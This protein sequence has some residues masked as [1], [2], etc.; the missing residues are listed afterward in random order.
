MDPSLIHLAKT[1][2]L[3]FTDALNMKKKL[4]SIISTAAIVVSTLMPL[5]SAKAITMSPLFFDY[6]LNPGDTV[7]D[8]IKL[9][10]ETD[11]DR[12]LYPLL[13]NFTYKEGNEDGT[14]EFYMPDQDPTGNALAQWITTDLNPIVIKA[15]ERVNVQFAINVPQNNVQPGGHY[16]A[17]LF[18]TQPPQDD[19]QVGIGGTLGEL[20]LVRVA[21]DVKEE[22]RILEFGFDPKKLWYNY[23][24][25][26]MYV[27]FENDGNTHLRPTGNIFIKNW[28]GRQVASIEVNGS[29]NSV[30]PHSIRRFS[31][32]WGNKMITEPKGFYGKLKHEIRNFGF[33]KYK[34]ELFLNYGSKN[35]V[36]SETRE[37]TIWPWRTMIVV[38]V[39]LLLI[40]TLSWLW[41]KH[42]DKAVIRR[43]ERNMKR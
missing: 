18:A 19:G 33:G 34:A 35:A 12:T 25:V 37:F 4:L 21:G 42:Y 2:E 15:N 26:D 5:A 29:F 14:P 11:V 7:L 43:Y 30:L 22:A 28:Y 20:I 39:G 24:P 41:K 3:V 31:A 13:R 38:G 17:I 27:R 9:Y 1:A 36:V 6:T 40:V 10:N 32:S 23:K 8:V 16:G